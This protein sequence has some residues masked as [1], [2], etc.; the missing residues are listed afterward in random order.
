VVVDRAFERDA[1]AASAEYGGL[2]R[3]DLE[4]FVSREVIAAAVVPSR[5][6]L[7]PVSGIQYLAFVDPSG[8]S[9]DSMTLAVA[10]REPDGRAVLDAVR[11][12]RPP[13]SPEAV[14]EEFATLLKAYRINQVEGD[15]YGGEWPRERFRIHGIMY[16]SAENPEQSPE[17]CC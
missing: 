9:N 6:E 16:T 11:E 1:A 14:V 7:Q 10:H 5:H 3:A 4:A 2:F 13:F 12:R 17:A 15:R 8:G